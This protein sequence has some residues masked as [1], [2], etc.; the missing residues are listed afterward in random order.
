M[1]EDV[2][3]LKAQ[4]KT[5]RSTIKFLR[6][7]MCI[8]AFGPLA[9]SIMWTHSQHKWQ[10]QAKEHIAKLADLNR[11]VDE[12]GAKVQEYAALV[13]KMEENYKRAMLSCGSHTVSFRW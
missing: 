12:Y 5:L 3:E 8:L 2:E 9:S 11:Q 10:A 1:I 4:I 13:S 6:I 7:S